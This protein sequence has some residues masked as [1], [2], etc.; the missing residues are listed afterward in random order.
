MYLP[1]GRSVLRQTSAKSY[2]RFAAITFEKRSRDTAF[3]YSK[4]YEFRLVGTR[5]DREV[6]LSEAPK[7]QNDLVEVE[8]LSKNQGEALQRPD[9]F[10]HIRQL[11]SP[12]LHENRA[13]HFGLTPMLQADSPLAE[14]QNIHPLLLYQHL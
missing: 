9:T 7:T 8:S 2:H 11:F 5:N 14:K 13:L 1:S 10:H 4:S 3:G 12:T 6:Y